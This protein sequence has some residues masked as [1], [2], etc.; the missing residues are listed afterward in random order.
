METLK[1]EAINAISKLPESAGVDDIMYRIYVIDT[2]K[3]GKTKCQR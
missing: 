3:K 2:I 1:K